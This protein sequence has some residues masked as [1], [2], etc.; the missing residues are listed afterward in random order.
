MLLENYSL[1]GEQSGHV[2]FRDFATTG[3]GQLTAALQL[4]LQWYGYGYCSNCSINLLQ[5][6]NFLISEDYS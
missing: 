1:G 4:S 2:I 5:H 6:R 3:D